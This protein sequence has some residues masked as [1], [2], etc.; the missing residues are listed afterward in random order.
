MSFGVSTK[1]TSIL[2]GEGG[3]VTRENIFFIDI[4]RVIGFLVFQFKTMRETT[5]IPL[6]NSK[7][8]GFAL[9]VC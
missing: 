1:N 9:V 7:P 4:G 3:A 5:V 6:V 8:F 2:K